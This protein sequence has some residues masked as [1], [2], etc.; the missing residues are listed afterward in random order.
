MAP[1]TVGAQEIAVSVAENFFTSNPPITRLVQEPRHFQAFDVGIYWK[2]THTEAARPY[3]SP[4][5]G[6]G[7]SYANLGSCNCIPGSRMG[8]SFTIYAHFDRD[9]LQLGAFSAG[10]DIELGAAL[11]TKYYDRF[12]N[13]GNLLYG[14]PYTNHFKMGFF[15]RVQ[16]SQNLALRAEVNFRHNSTARLII[17]NAGVNSVSCALGAAYAIGKNNLKPGSRRPE[18]DPLD[19]EFRVAVF[20]A[21]GVHRCMAE[22]N[23]DLKLPPEERQDSYTPW[24]K[25]SVGAE[26]NWRY[27]RR[28]STGA[29][30]EF[31]YL[32]NTD[33]LRRSDTALY[34]PGERKY[35]PF[36][37]GIG[38]IQDLYFGSFTV[39]VG[40]GAYL[41]K[42]TG[43]HEDHGRLY[44][45]VNIRYYPPA[46]KRIFAGLA[47]RAH[48]FNQ[49]D[50]LE[51]SIGTVL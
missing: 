21:G 45:K 4:R 34:G 9:L 35:S 47:I 50:Y 31:H 48:H 3:S 1:A 36:A 28:T 49:A 26:L 23:A 12:D 29:Q 24:F 37:P 27:S 30:A 38:L 32:S 14:G 42:E 20:G 46:L 33:A 2:P 13:P 25:G 22:F 5:F 15:S 51:F 40:V 43:I 19:K 17:P 39:G 8:D 44:Q 10:Y 7:F 6:L 18:A 11:M 41:F 16:V